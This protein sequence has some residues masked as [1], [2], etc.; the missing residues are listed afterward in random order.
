MTDLQSI[1]HFRHL[2]I[3]EL[4]VQTVIFSIHQSMVHVGL[5]HFIIVL[6]NLAS[7]TIR[8][9]NG[10]VYLQG[11]HVA[12]I[13]ATNM[14]VHRPT[15]LP[16]NV[17]SPQST[18]RGHSTGLIYTSWK[19]PLNITSLIFHILGSNLHQRQ[20]GWVDMSF[21]SSPCRCGKILKSL[22]NTSFFPKHGPKLSCGLQKE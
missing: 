22:R 11:L 7:E 10:Y 9:H 17:H 18:C 3:P 15:S 21:I 1:N 8:S 4:M 20:V 14:P 19:V 12:C 2:Y 16:V 6:A 5:L 13:L